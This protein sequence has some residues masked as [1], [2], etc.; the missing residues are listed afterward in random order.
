MPSKTEA[1]TL[2]N[3]RN[4]RD[5]DDIVWYQSE[6]DLAPM[7]PVSS[8]AVSIAASSGSDNPG[9]DSLDSLDLP[10]AVTA[11]KSR[12]KLP[13]AAKIL[14]NIPLALKV[15]SKRVPKRSWKLKGLDGPE[16][17][18]AVRGNCS[19]SGH[20]QEDKSDEPE[21]QEKETHPFFKGKVAKPSGTTSAK[22]KK[23]GSKY[24]TK[25]AK[26]AGS[27]KR[28]CA[29]SNTQHRP[30]KLEKA[31]NG[32]KIPPAVKMGNDEGNTAD[33]ED[34]DDKGEDEDEDEDEEDEDAITRY[35]K[36]R[37]E[38]QHDR[39]TLRK[40]V[41]RGNDACTQDI[42]LIS[43]AGTRTV[44]G[45]QLK[46]H[47]CEI[48][49]KVKK[50]SDDSSFFM[51]G[52]SSLR[53]H[54]SRNWESHGEQ[55]LKKCKASKIEPH[56]RAL[57]IKIEEEQEEKIDGF[58]KPA[59]KWTKEGLLEHIIE[60]VVVDDQPFTIVEK[61]PFKA[62]LKF[63]RPSTKDSDI[64]G[65]SKITEEIMEKAKV[66]EARLRKHFETL[67]G[68]ISITFDAWT[69]GSQDPYLAVC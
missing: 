22:T 9:T 20:G 52:G 42:R 61:G 8:A 7:P 26:T 24:N 3:D 58:L 64:P 5:A 17:R 30:D 53:K 35:E 48:C 54:I 43:T 63:Q 46:G 68:Q 14:D 2:D 67:P 11:L 12:R 28:K 16:Y 50:L 65:R 59:P 49:K 19:V 60:F 55:Y 25:G 21:A 69:S 45:E 27:E 23:T 40:H 33:D 13:N 37:D 15:S 18:T 4:L 44:D 57:A 6:T 36:I 29:K 51:G 41:H 1:F 10:T 62:I 32:G 47:W 31:A 56:P 39:Q 38:V 66:V 34:G